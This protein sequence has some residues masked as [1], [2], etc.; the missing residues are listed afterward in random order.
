MISNFW[1]VLF[2]IYVWDDVF[3]IN[4]VCITGLKNIFYSQ[5]NYFFLSRSSFKSTKLFKIVSIQTFCCSNIERS[6]STK[7]YISLEL[8]SR[9][10]SSLVFMLIAITIYTDASF[11]FLNKVTIYSCASIV[12]P[13]FYMTRH[14]DSLLRVA[15]PL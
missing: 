14:S 3:D 13:Y 9:T 1:S 7:I 15:R 2:F 10:Y 5:L 6:P 12:S 11:I 8:S 4:I